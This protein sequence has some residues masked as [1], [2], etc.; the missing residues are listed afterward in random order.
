MPPIKTMIEIAK[1]AFFMHVLILT[2]RKSK[3]IRELFAK[4]SGAGTTPTAF[5]FSDGA[6]SPL[7]YGSFIGAKEH[8]KGHGLRLL[9]IR[10]EKRLLGREWRKLRYR[11][12]K[13]RPQGLGLSRR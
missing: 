5:Y 4:P 12:G 9:Q 7:G 13:R 2:S 11:I 6:I 1:T 3:R 10:I 8:H